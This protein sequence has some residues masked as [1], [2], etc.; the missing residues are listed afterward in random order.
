MRL[1]TVSF[2]V[3]EEVKYVSLFPCRFTSERKKKGYNFLQD[4]W[5]VVNLSFVLIFFPPHSLTDPPFSLTW[6]IHIEFPLMLIS[7]WPVKNRVSEVGQHS[8]WSPE[9]TCMHQRIITPP[10][11]PSPPP[12]PMSYPRRLCTAELMEGLALAKEHKGA[13]WSFILRLSHKGSYLLTLEQLGND[14]LSGAYSEKPG[15]MGGRGGGKQ[16]SK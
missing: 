1:L 8:D 6:F 15:H 2:W 12:P 11:S 14:Q 7:L 16:K 10:S 5:A 9:A 13:G 4:C 3:Y